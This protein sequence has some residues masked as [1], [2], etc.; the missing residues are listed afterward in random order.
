MLL[1][2]PLT[3]PTVGIPVLLAPLSRLLA[4]RQ[5]P[6]L[7]LKGEGRD[8]VQP[9]EPRLRF[10]GDREERL[11]RGGVER[12]GSPLGSPD[13]QVPGCFG[14]ALLPLLCWML[15]NVTLHRSISA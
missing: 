14:H 2:E 5:L 15:P 9:G 7:P 6:L 12:I 13:Q 1:R 3:N 10:G 4:C 11:A 8:G